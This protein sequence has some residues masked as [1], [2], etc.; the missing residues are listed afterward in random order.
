MLSLDL[1]LKIFV[2]PAYKN[3]LENPSG[4]IPENPVAG[5]LE[6]LPKNISQS[7]SPPRT[8]FSYR[9]TARP[10]FSESRRRPVTVAV[11]LCIVMVAVLVA[12]GCVDQQSRYGQNSPASGPSLNVVPTMPLP[13]LASSN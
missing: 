10:I 9:M 2:H 5:I 13:S 11:A 12:A 8:D 7:I 1:F 6:S 4:K 3:F